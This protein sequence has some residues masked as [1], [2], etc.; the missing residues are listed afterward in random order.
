MFACHGAAN[1]H[2]HRVAASDM[3]FR[4]RPAR[5]SGAFDCYAVLADAEQGGPT[6]DYAAGRLGTTRP[7]AVCGAGQWTRRTSTIRFLVPMS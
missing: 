4:K 1:D 3:G 6:A 2:N 7:L 5:N